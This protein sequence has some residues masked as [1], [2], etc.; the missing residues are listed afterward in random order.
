[1][2]MRGG[3]GPK[4]R[5]RVVFVDHVARLS[6]GEIALLRL[7]PTLSRHVDVLVIL[8][9]SGPLEERLRDAGITVEVLQLP[10]KVRDLRRD[11]VRPG[12]LGVTV[13]IRALRYALMLRRRIRE[14]EADIV[15]TNS[16][17][18]AL[19]GGIAGRLA[20][21]FVVWHIRDRISDDY[22][23]GPA[24][25]IVR[26]VS[27]FVPHAIIANSQETL[28]TVPRGRASTV[29]YN[30][31]VPDSP[32][33]A[34]RARRPTEQAPAVVGM[35]GR[36]APWKGQDVFIDA[37]ALAFRG[38]DVRG[39]LIGEA[40]FGED[41]F[42]LELH[43]RASDRGVADQLEFR[44][45]REDI[46]AELHE[47]DVLVHCSVRPEPFGQ[48]VLEGLAAGVPVVAARAG[49]PAEVITNDVNGILTTP[50][51]AEELA[52][53]LR[54]LVDDPDLRMRLAIAGR[55]RSR[56]FSPEQTVERLLAVY[57]YVT[58]RR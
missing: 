30:P 22:L 8:G 19:Y 50:G 56:D 16:L 13:P 35:L 3:E 12:R 14:A 41:E 9:E 38:T 1:M 5:L 57:A 23:P 39:R 32:G 31:I 6:G 40:L 20:P 33:R 34:V 51:D 28:S 52:R 2:A 55:W 27:R 4:R 25:R 36:L 18:A 24:V 10:E 15:H 48:V 37:F 58:D 53:Q 47:L 42:A 49:G 44:G 29:V 54:R 26:A 21:A 17:K 7:L 11:R 45:F 46:W 43:A